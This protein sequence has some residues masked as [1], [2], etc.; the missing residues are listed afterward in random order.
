MNGGGLRLSG[1]TG[2]FSGAYDTYV[3]NGGK[4]GRATR[5][6]GPMPGSLA[7]QAANQLNQAEPGE[8]NTTLRRP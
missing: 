6:Y 5:F 8:W 4:T 7:S 3:V 1:P 2:E